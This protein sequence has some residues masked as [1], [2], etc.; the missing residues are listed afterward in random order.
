MRKDA[1][2]LVSYAVG[3]NNV[4]VRELRYF[5]AV[6]KVLLVHT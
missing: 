6:T 4:E 1:F 5:I 3:M 2:A